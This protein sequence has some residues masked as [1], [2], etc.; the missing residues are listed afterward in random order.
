MFG[1]PSPN[2][3]RLIREQLSR[4]YTVRDVDLS[5]GR[6]PPDVNTLVIIGPR[7]L[8]EKAR[9]AIDQYLMQ[10]GSVVIAGGPYA[11]RLDFGSPMLE[12][13]ITGMDELLTHYGIKVGQSLVMDPRNEPFPVE[14]NRNLGGITVR[15]IQ[16]VR[17]PFFVDVRPDAMDRSSPIVSR[18]PAVTM[19]F[20]SPIE[21]DAEKNKARKVTTLLRSTDQA[22]LRTGTDI[23]PNFA[24]NPEFGF[25]VEGERKSYPLA[26]AVQGTF[27]SFF[28][29][30]PSPL[31]ATP[32]PA[33]TPLPGATPEPTPTPEP[34]IPVGATIEQ[35][36]DTARL[37]VIGSA[38]FLNDALM[39]LS[40]Q[41]GQER[42]L[43]SLQFIQNVTDWSV[44]DLELL[45]IRSRGTVT[46]TLVPLTDGERRTW[47]IA[48]YVV[49]LIALFGIG[50]LWRLRQQAEPIM[51]LAP[52]VAD[53]RA[54]RK[55]VN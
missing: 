45:D 17:Y 34:A 28:K 32:T 22:W 47:E 41:L 31:Q 18:L 33:P 9:Y 35:S 42:Y 21:V 11:L 52:A 10:G 14:V 15:E 4:E 38:E 30:K 50:A 26:V 19:N 7:N 13:V 53:G 1:A 51:Q 23:Q 36:P 29:G 3:W 5:T 39:N 25:P 2:T 46:R 40:A 48:N 37:V 55:E 54:S 49:M 20:V 44:E 27:E 6:V 43:N 12:Q 16:A 8:D 24:A